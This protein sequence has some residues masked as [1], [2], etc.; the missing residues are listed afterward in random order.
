[1]SDS[2][3]REAAELQATCS[4][5]WRTCDR[6]TREHHILREMPTTYGT[7]NDSQTVVY[8]SMNVSGR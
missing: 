2:L 3:R 4:A 8:W 7:G 6:E 5:T 1:M